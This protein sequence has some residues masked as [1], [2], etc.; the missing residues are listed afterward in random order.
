V[1][2]PGSDG[3]EL[4]DE[5]RLSSS[6]IRLDSTLWSSPANWNYGMDNVQAWMGSILQYIIRRASA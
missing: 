3:A 6:T 4:M 5:L 1:V 2:I